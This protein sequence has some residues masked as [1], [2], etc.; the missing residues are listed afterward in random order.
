MFTAKAWEQYGYWPGADRQVL[1]KRNLL[2]EDCRRLPFAGIGK[3]EPLR[4]EFSGFWSRRMTDEH[5]LVYAV[6]DYPAGQTLI[7]A[8]CRFHY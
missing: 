3:P 6:E 5:R 1:K 8:Q 4:G 2:I 7:I